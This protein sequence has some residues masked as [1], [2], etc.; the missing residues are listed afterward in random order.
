MHKFLI[1]VLFL[2]KTVEVAGAMALHAVFAVL[3][4][5]VASSIAQD[6]GAYPPEPEPYPP[7][8]YPPETYPPSKPDAYPPVPPK[9]EPYI[10]GVPE[11]KPYPP[12]EPYP[13]PEPYPPVLPP[14]G[15]G[16]V[17]GYDYSGDPLITLR[18]Q[19]RSRIADAKAKIASVIEFRAVTLASVEKISTLSMAWC[20]SK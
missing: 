19:V 5:T 2:W 9:Y 7:Q 6:T 1:T 15:Y 17:S 16:M 10:P 3:L 20:R 14:A 12:S 11:P 8:P 13:P 4:L 18:E